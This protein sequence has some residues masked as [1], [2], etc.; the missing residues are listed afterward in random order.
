VSGPGRRPTRLVGAVLLVCA[1]AWVAP[2]AEA[3]PVPVGATAPAP[4]LQLLGQS[5][6]VESGQRLHLQLQVPSAAPTDRLEVLLGSRLTTRSG[7]DADVRY[8]VHGSTVGAYSAPAASLPADPAGGVDVDIPIN[9]ATPA[10]T[11]FSVQQDVSGV[12]PVTIEELGGNGQQVGT[13]VTTFLVYASPAAVA[14]STPGG[15]S[16]GLPRLDVA[17]NVPV[18]AALGIG[19]QGQP[20]RLAPTASSALA[21]EVNTLSAHPGVPLTLDASPATLDSLTVGGATDR[22]TLAELQT[23]AIDDEVA[24]RPYAPV[25]LPSLMAAGLGAEI[26]AQLQGGT[27]AATTDLGHPPTAG[28]LLV[29]GPFDQSTAGQLAAD[30]INQMVVPSSDLSALPASQSQTTVASP[31]AL[32]IKGAAPAKVVNVDQGL[33]S[34][35]AGGAGAVLRANRLLAELAMVQLETPGE[36]RGV[37]LVPPTGW[38]ATP[39]FLT[40]ILTGLAANPLLNPVT[41]SSLF[42]LPTLGGSSGLSRSLTADHPTVP[43]FPDPDLVQ[44]ARQAVGAAT[45]ILPPTKG[46]AAA[47]RRSL[48]LAESDELPAATQRRLI[49][50]VADSLT[51]VRRSIS[52]PSTS[53]TLTAQDGDVPITVVAASGLTG[54]RVQLRLSSEKLAFRYFKPPAGSCSIPTSDIEVCQ[55][56]LTGEA[57]TLKVP[58]VARASGVFTLGVALSSPDGAVPLSRSR[59][60]VR[61]TAFSG[62]GVVI[63]VVAGLALLYWWIRNLRHGRRAKELVPPSEDELDGADDDVPGGAGEGATPPVEPEEAPPVHPSDPSWIDDDPVIAEF[64]SSPAPSFPPRGDPPSAP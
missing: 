4:G 58:V 42:A 27:Q 12:Y 32:D 23:L 5:P 11:S 20:G 53:V 63:M 62:V 17:L 45:T 19:A 37:A 31:A 38:Q 49:S 48:L 15:P 36:Q 39:T 52:V 26:T 16:D 13:P 47:L 14:A 24:E 61:S 25:S 43:G 55:L 30:G 10:A 1:S 29:D 6:F 41:T 22:A 2:P 59:D 3:R 46:Q 8:G 51:R 28:T 35:F 50:T 54:A 7:F 34:D 60:T 56:T 21:A 44:T 57:T 64:F 40:T 33:Q 9:P 18:Q